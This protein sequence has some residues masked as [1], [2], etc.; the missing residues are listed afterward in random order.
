MMKYDI[1]KHIFD[2]EMSFMTRIREVL[3]LKM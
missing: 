1:L 3:V 2:S